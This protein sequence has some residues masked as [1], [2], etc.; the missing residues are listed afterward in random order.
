MQTTKYNFGIKKSSGLFGW[1]ILA[2]L[3]VKL[4]YRFPQQQQQTLVIKKSNSYYSRT[5]L[6]KVSQMKL[7]WWINDIEIFNE[8]VLVQ[9]PA[10]VLLRI[11]CFF[12]RLGCCVGR[13]SNWRDMVLDRKENA[14]EWSETIG[15]GASSGRHFKT[16]RE[17]SVH[18][19]MDNI[20]A[21]NF[22]IKMG[23]TMN[24]KMICLFREIWELLLNNKITV[25]AEYMPSLRNVQEDSEAH[26][27]AESA[28]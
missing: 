27:K 15:F 6:S 24:L 11:R 22:F 26:C 25:T 5:L 9:A 14:Y 28:K 1:T 21:L 10:Q 4:D 13:N 16:K 18:I 2:I 20:F 23:V 19:Q 12:N 17:T 8:R 7:L 3:L